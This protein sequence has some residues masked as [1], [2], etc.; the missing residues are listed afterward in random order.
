MSS[1]KVDVTKESM[2]LEYV[3]EGIKSSKDAFH[4]AVKALWVHSIG[5]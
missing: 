3:S 4:Y 2:E 5:H 1:N